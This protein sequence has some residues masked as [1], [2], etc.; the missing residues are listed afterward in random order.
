MNFKEHAYEH[1]SRYKK[2]RLGIHRCG[3][4]KGVEYSHI[5]PWD[6]RKAN[7]LDSI[8]ATMW[9]YIAERSAPTGPV[10]KGYLHQCFHH[11]NSSQ[12]MCMNLFFPFVQKGKDL[13]E[14][15]LK[16]AGASGAI[17]SVK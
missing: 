10:G 11:L 6:Q 17:R 9:D 1:L 13:P 7:F 16:Q 3:Y 12:A 15:L 4:W 14:I 8:R 5:L 2:E